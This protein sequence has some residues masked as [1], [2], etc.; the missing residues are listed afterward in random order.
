LRNAI[1]VGY[2]EIADSQGVHRFGKYKEGQNAVRITVNNDLFYIRVL[3]SA[4]LGLSESYM[5]SDID[6]DNLKGVMDVG[7]RLPTFF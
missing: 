1:K 3:A 7:H 5:T 4:D 2:L 6:V